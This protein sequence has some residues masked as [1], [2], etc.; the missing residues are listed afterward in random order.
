VSQLDRSLTSRLAPENRV[1]EAEVSL[2]NKGGEDGSVM[3]TLD[4]EGIRDAGINVADPGDVTSYYMYGEQL[5]VFDL[6]GT[7]D[8]NAE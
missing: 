5:L 1:R 2:Q 6:G 7:F 4:K 3:G 8:G